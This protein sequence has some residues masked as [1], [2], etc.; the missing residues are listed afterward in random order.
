MGG[1]STR[2]DEKNPRSSNN[3]ESTPRPNVAQLYLVRHGTTTWNVTNRYR[4]RR[5][6]PLDT[7]GWADASAAA[8]QLAPLNL[9]A[10]YAGPLQRCIDTARVIADECG[11]SEVRIDDGFYNLDYGV[12][13]GMTAQEAAAHD[14]EMFARYVGSPLE[15]VCPDGERLIDAQDR[16]VE[17]IRSIG[18]H[19]VGE[20]VACVTH[21][22]MIRLLAAMLLD[23]RDEGWRIPVGRGSLTKLEVE[24]GHIRLLQEPEGDDVD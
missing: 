13:E 3:R 18:E 22:V 1:D 5:D 16:I 7:Q 11:V 15:A 4:G 6:V 20:A 9:R 21:A 2:A 23:R 12:W 24:G 14:P 17:A 8:R 10:V 19:H